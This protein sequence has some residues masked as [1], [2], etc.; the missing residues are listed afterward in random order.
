MKVMTND[1][2]VSAG[3]PT[4]GEF[5]AH[6]RAESPVALRARPSDIVI[7]LVVP[8]ILTERQPINGYPVSLPAPENV[9]FTEGDESSAIYLNMTV[10]GVEFFVWSDEDGDP[11]DSFDDDDDELPPWSGDV[12]CELLDWAHATQRAVEEDFHTATGAA[13]SSTLPDAIIANALGRGATAIRSGYTDVEDVAPVDFAVKRVT[14]QFAAS[15]GAEDDYENVQDALTDLV[16]YARTKGL[17]IGELFTAATRMAATEY[18]ESQ[19]TS[20]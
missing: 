16:H 7:P 8:V 4:G 13:M 19:A 2:R 17:D 14:Q 10:E 3:I 12:H 18:R 6:D 1:K 15:N 11:R 9:S 5:A 20:E